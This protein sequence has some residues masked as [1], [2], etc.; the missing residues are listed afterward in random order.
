MKRK[1]VAALALSLT[2]CGPAL[3]AP[4]ASVPDSGR[5]TFDVIRN[6]RDIGDYVVTFRGKANDLT[7][8]VNT[9]VS[10]KV[11]VIGVSAY[12]F[13][14][15]STESWRGGSLAGLASQTDDNGTPHR[16]S[17]GA[18]PLVPASLWNADIVHVSQVLNTIDGSTDSIRV[19]DLGAETI[20][21]GAGPVQARHYALRGD[22]NR[23]L[24]FAGDKL[25]H[26]RFSA[27]DGSQV[28]YV[29]R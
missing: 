28:D 9:D 22:L 19:S 26:V 17:L 8:N 2:A 20:S 15:A 10:V 23:D 4:A 16:I 11:P 21:T 18:T 24:W 27:D 13:H 25:V 1:L 7:V 14:Q 12:R 3:A 6:G 5:L 29:L